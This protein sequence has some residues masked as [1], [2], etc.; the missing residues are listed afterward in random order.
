MKNVILLAL[1]AI[2]MAVH[3]QVSSYATLYCLNPS[4]HIIPVLQAGT[5]APSNYPGVQAFGTNSSKQS[6][7][8]LCDASG[9]LTS[10][11]PGWTVTGSGSSQVVT[12]PGT[13]VVGTSAAKNSSSIGPRYDVTQFGAVGNG[14][15]DDT[16]AIQSALN[17][18]FNGGNAPYQGIVEFPGPHSY[19]ISS[20]LYA[21]WGCGL[22][23]T[24]G[25]GP[26]NNTPPYLLW[27]GPATGA[28]YTI[29]GIT[30]VHGSTSSTVVYTANNSLSVGDW[31]IT[32]GMTTPTGIFLNKLVSQVTAATSATFTVTIPFSVASISGVAD[33]GTATTTSVAVEFGTAG[34]I[35]NLTGDS[36]TNLV[37]R[38]IPGFATANGLGVGVLF[39]RRTDATSKII[40]TWSEGAKYFDFDFSA[41]G[42]NTYFDGGARADG[43]GYAGIY[44]R[45]G[46]SD[47]LGISN[48]T[49]TSVADGQGSPIMVDSTNCLPYD[50]MHL[51]IRNTKVEDNFIMASGYGAITF[52]DCPSNTDV[53]GLFLDTENLW[54]TASTTAA[55]PALLVSPPND[56]AVNLSIV[57]GQFYGGT[58]QAPFV[59]IPSLARYT[60]AGSLGYLPL[61]SYSPSLNSMGASRSPGQV[62]F[63]APTQLIGDVNLGQ[64]WQYGIP[65][66]HY[67][68]SDTAFAALPN[69]TTLYAGQI[70]APPAYW[71]GANGK[72]YALDVVYQTGTTGT[73]N[74]GAT[75]CTAPGGGLHEL[76]CTSATDLNTG[77]HITVGSTV[78]N[79]VINYVDATN[80][81]SVI[82]WIPINPGTISTPTALTFTAPVLGPEIQMPTKSS[83]VPT[84]LTWAQGDWEQNSGAAAN[85]IAAWVNVAAGTPGTWAAVPLGNSSG[86]LSI[87]QVTGGTQSA[88]PVC[89]NGAGGTL[90]TAGCSS[91]G[92]AAP[93]TVAYLAAPVV[94][95][96]S[97]SATQVASLK[98]PAG[99]LTATG[100]LKIEIKTEACGSGGTP[101]T[102]C[103]VANTGTCTLDAYFTTTNTGTTVH[104]LNLPVTIKGSS[105]S[106]YS[107][108]AQ[109]STSSQVIDG[110]SN[111]YSSATTGIVN[112][113]NPLSV[114][115]A[116]DTYINLFETNSVSADK[117]AVSQ[118]DIEL[119][120]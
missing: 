16:A 105:S 41:G 79:Q 12:A 17:A 30:M 11:P 86:Q 107:I 27:N 58:G 74:A 4:G 9:N 111:Y 99:T 113:V 44:W 29:T 75:T 83:A 15:T 35:Q 33:T 97:T 25:N 48:I 73:P 49:E 91:T 6:T 88:L 82:V 116:A 36:I 81:A 92:V 38:N 51:T 110:D 23:G 89:P 22:E 37:V 94:N 61:L 54:I 78:I 31:V 45:V 104:F 50:G 70:L 42:I 13:L 72:R 28:V 19:V 95:T 3:G 24:W 80:P 47:S 5:P 55:A 115:M 71:S 59:G 112:L 85:G 62:T 84:T 10:L 43:Y 21:N 67:L 120:P 40:G 1:L 119:W 14:S 109:G 63:T 76:V 69:G 7:P 98:V 106:R 57:N 103:S 65:A 114:N 2:P 60:V 18:C 34:F 102:G 8:L 64:I 96:G 66:S 101:F 52:L 39:A 90:T 87:S 46:A 56:E 26:G 20:T 117:C 93:S 77:Q 32:E 108:R 100:R 118:A 68:Y 53:T